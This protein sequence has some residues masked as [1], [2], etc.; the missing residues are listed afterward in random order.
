MNGRTNVT[1]ENTIGALI[2]LEPVTDAIAVG[3]TNSVVLRW[4]D[5]VDKYSDPGD[6]LVAEWDR[7][8]VIRKEGAV[9]SSETDGTVIVSEN[10]RNQYSKVDYRDENLTNGTTYH[11]S[12]YSYTKDGIV[13][14]AVSLS[15][16][17][18]NNTIEFADNADPFEVPV[19]YMAAKP[20]G[21]YVI[22]HGGMNYDPSDILTKNQRYAYSKD[23]TR[24]KIPPYS[25]S[26]GIDETSQNYHYFDSA[27]IDRAAWFVGGG[28]D[29]DRLYTDDLTTRYTNTHYDNSFYGAAVFALGDTFVA[30]GGSTT[31]GGDL[32][33]IATMTYEYT[34][35]NI[36][37]LPNSYYLGSFLSANT[38]ARTVGIFAG[39]SGSGWNSAG[40]YSFSSKYIFFMNDDMTC[41]QSPSSMNVNR[42]G[43]YGGF[44]GGMDGYVV[45]FSGASPYN[46]YDVVT[47]DVTLLAD[48]PMPSVTA[49]RSAYP[50][51]TNDYTA[52]IGGDERPTGNTIHQK[53]FIIDTNLTFITEELNT[54]RT[55]C[56]AAINDHV[57]I[58]GGGSLSGAQGGSTKYLSDVEMYIG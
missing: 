57:I 6:E 17:P 2:P 11:Y 26:A 27:T 46:T 23:G 3:R 30:A 25:G 37:N 19:A 39:G 34:F 55:Q 1:Q 28:T 8:I 14:E 4:D 35:S 43:V 29:I 20:A 58:I 41:Q 10:M 50:V 40:S 15:A 42:R 22:F 56:G 45:M 54:P 16:T 18:T 31:S 36:G 38:A 47:E 7:T 21:D 52:F 48:Q 44:G 33:K 12:I 5:P 13:S 24:I 9:P 32:S 49:V 53:A 51:S